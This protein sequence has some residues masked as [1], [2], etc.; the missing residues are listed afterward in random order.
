MQLSE[1]CEMWAELE[2]L[3]ITGGCNY[4]ERCHDADFCGIDVQEA[5]WLALMNQDFLQHVHVVPIK[6]SLL[7][8][9]PVP[10]TD[11]AVKAIEEFCFTDDELLTIRTIKNSPKEIDLHLMNTT[12]LSKEKEAL[13][14]LFPP[15]YD[16]LAPGFS[17]NNPASRRYNRNPDQAPDGPNRGAPYH[18]H[19]GKRYYGGGGGSKYAPL[20]LIGALALSTCLF[21]PVD[22]STTPFEISNQTTVWRYDPRP[23]V[24]GF[25][26]LEI[27][28]DII[29]P[30]DR[31]ENAS[32]KATPSVLNMIHL[33]RNLH[34]EYFLNELLT[35][36]TY[37]NCIQFGRQEG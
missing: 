37:W 34:Q 1:I 27:D 32:G 24:T 14:L 6:P 18:W 8:M 11:R 33:C 23:V 10:R 7:T 3:E 13:R 28:I 16:P 20:S 9:R 12:F 30:C 35:L 21:P 29:S 2:D 5:A 26:N 17:G 15:P 22:T 19:K 4:L 31:F 36:R 25:D